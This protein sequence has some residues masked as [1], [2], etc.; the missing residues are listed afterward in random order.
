LSKK[1]SGQSCASG[2]SEK[3]LYSE[4]AMRDKIHSSYQSA[5][6]D[7]RGPS[8]NLKSNHLGDTNARRNDS[9]GSAKTQECTDQQ[10]MNDFFPSKQ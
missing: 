1:G 5:G 8:S 4:V 10:K 6:A 7:S 3:R 2:G 9:H